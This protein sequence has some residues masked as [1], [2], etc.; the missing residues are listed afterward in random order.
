M[1]LKK[2]NFSKQKE[3]RIFR[4]VFAF[5]ISISFKKLWKTY[6]E[7]L[8]CKT[9]TYLSFGHFLIS[10]LLSYEINGPYPKDG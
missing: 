10:F 4:G 7:I 6:N 9:V 8:V 1:A 3:K 2:N 5:L